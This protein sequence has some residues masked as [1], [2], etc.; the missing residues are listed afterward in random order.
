MNCSFYSAEEMENLFLPVLTNH[1][2]V[3]QLILG[4]MIHVKKLLARGIP[5]P[6]Y[7]CFG[8]LYGGTR[9]EPLWLFCNFLPYASG[10]SG[11]NRNVFHCSSN[12]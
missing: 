2:D 1:E 7:T 9:E 3:H 12:R 11:N 5:V 10:S 6:E 8:A 4:N